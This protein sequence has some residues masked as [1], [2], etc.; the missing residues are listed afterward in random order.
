MVK[1]IKGKKYSTETATKLADWDNSY[2][3]NDHKYISETL[4]QKRTGEYFLHGEGGGLTRYATSVGN[5]YTYGER[6][7]PITEEEA[8]EWAEEHLDGEGYEKI[9]GTVEELEDKG[10]KTISLSVAVVTAEKLKR[11]AVSKGITVSSLVDNIVS[12]MSE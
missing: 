10:R 3:I 12:D 5:A 1:F 2:S 6:I 8:R 4:Y 11:L 7:I 9:F